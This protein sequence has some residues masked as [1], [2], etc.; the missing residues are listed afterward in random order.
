M[1]NCASEPKTNEGP[2][3]I[4]EKPELLANEEKRVEQVETKV[5]EKNDEP[6]KEETPNTDDD[7]SLGTLLNEVWYMILELE[8]FF[9]VSNEDKITTLWENGSF[10]IPL[11][12]TLLAWFISKIHLLNDKDDFLS[13]LLSNS[14]KAS[15]CLHDLIRKMNDAV[16]FE[17]QDHSS[18]SDNK[19]FDENPFH[20]SNERMF[21]Y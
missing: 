14:W 5:E 18:A 20:N 4:E 7:K 6:K 1:G 21:F 13:G 10:P 16:N 8:W 2:A 12:T 19:Q 17:F 11:D 15:S 9:L 3:P